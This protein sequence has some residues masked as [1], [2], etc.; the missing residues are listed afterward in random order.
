MKLKSRVEG[1]NFKLLFKSTQCSQSVWIALN[2]KFH[3]TPVIQGDTT[4][5]GQID[6]TFM[7]HFSFICNILIF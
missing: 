7:S 1:R 6:G 2:I 3:S 5:L 4:F